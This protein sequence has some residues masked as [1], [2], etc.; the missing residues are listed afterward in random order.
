MTPT[1]TPPVEPWDLWMLVG[2]RADGKTYSAL[3]AVPDL[4]APRQVALVIG[5]SVNHLEWLVDE[6]RRNH[7]ADVT[8]FNRSARSAQFRNDSALRFL[9][10]AQV[11]HDRVHFGMRANVA[12][13]D[14][15]SLYTRDAD[16]VAAELRVMCRVERIVTTSGETGEPLVLDVK[17]HPLKVREYQPLELR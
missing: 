1:Y 12:L 8:S 16:R 13:L 4:L 2:A 5:A 15:V 17:K 9:T 14:E 3:N 7:S 6:F 11:I 10:V